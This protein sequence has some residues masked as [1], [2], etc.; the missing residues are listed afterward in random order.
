MREITRMRPESSGQKV[1]EL[2]YYAGH[3]G[4]NYDGSSLIAASRGRGG[5]EFDWNEFQTRTMSS[6]DQD[7][8]VF[9]DCCFAGLACQTREQGSKHK[10]SACEA[11]GTTAVPGPHSF[12]S[13]FTDACW[14]F[15]DEGFTLEQWAFATLKLARRRGGME[16]VCESFGVAEY[17]I[18]FE[19]ALWCERAEAENERQAEENANAMKWHRQVE[20]T[21]IFREIV[22]SGGM[23]D[24]EL[25][26]E[27]ETADIEASR[28]LT[29]PFSQIGV[30]RAFRRMRDQQREQNLT[31]SEKNDQ[32]YNTDSSGEESEDNDNESNDQESEDYNNESNDEK[33][34]DYN[35]DS[36]N[37]DSGYYDNGFGNQE[38]QY[39]GGYSGNQESGHY[40]SGSSDPYPEGQY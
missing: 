36:G 18:F 29:Q 3:G 15:G 27:E 12:T 14:T 39:K 1:L 25:P 35:N 28:S 37:Q 34:E 5:Q 11:E 21:A 22:A 38:W 24:A 19:P 4:R 17:P 26:T 2:V 20:I 13:F 6:A 23:T 16:P 33:S 30:Y 7:T 32:Y 8:V 40:G 9:L 31:G 10:F